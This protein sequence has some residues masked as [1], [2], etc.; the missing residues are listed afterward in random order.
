MTH[1]CNDPILCIEYV[2][3]KL[4]GTDRKTTLLLLNSNLAYNL[5]VCSYQNKVM[6]SDELPDGQMVDQWEPIGEDSV[7]TPLEVNSSPK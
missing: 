4:T 2:I 7:Q 3:L 1:L 6:V 5:A